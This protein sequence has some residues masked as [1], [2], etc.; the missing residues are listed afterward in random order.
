MNDIISNNT[1]E[2]WFYFIMT[3]YIQILLLIVVC[4]VVYCV[5]YLNYFN[6]RIFAMPI[7]HGVTNTT[8][9]HIKKHK[10]MKN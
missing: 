4:L 5:E 7:I 6:A 9:I 1:S 2:S 3:N 8:P 10:K